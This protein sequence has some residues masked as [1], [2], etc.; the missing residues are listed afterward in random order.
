M[1]SDLANSLGKLENVPIREVW[2][3]EESVFTPWLM[4]HIEEI[5]K[6]IN[7]EIEDLERESNV[8]TYTA[9]LTG[10]IAGTDN[11]VVIENQFGMS[12]HDHLGKLLTNISGKSAKIGI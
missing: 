8:G 5:N 7:V 11:Y 1:V 3:Y 6:L 10:K 4:E 12:N 2:K 9:D